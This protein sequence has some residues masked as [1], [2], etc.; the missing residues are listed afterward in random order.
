MST[1][2]YTSSINDIISDLIDEIQYDDNDKL[3]PTIQEIEDDLTLQSMSNNPL[4]KQ[5]EK[6]IE[7]LKSFWVVN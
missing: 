3:K 2:N 6:M 7:I 5:E 4:S 1:L